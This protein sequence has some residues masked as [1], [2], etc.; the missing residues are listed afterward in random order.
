M[1]RGHLAN[2]H[3]ELV[4][5]HHAIKRFRVANPSGAGSDTGGNAADTATEAGLQQ[6]VANLR[7]ENTV[8]DKYRISATMPNA[9]AN[10]RYNLLA[11][12]REHT[13]YTLAI[14]MS[15]AGEAYRCRSISAAQAYQTTGNCEIIQ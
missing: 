9:A 3:A 7:L 5:I 1:E 13:G 6:F 10:R 14:W 8:E 15:S 11:I 12:P 2:A 4:N